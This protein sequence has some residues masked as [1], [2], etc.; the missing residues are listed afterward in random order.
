MRRQLKRHLGAARQVPLEW[1]G[2]VDAVSD[3]Y[4]Q[5]DTDRA[6]LE[7]SLDLSSAELLDA[8]TRMRQS[9]SLLQA[10]LDSTADGI[11]VVDLEGRIVAVNRKFVLMWGI[12]DEV[13]IGRETRLALAHVREQLER[14][15]AFL[16]RLRELYAQP[17]L[18]SHDI[19]ELKDGRVFER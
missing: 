6:M 16:A 10:T 9:L 17:E 1:Q 3:A 18:E 8:N 15:E 5:A 19:L 4:D 12:R 7:R 2:L 14:P 11:L 13:L